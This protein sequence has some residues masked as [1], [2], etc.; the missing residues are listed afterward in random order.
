M[1]RDIVKGAAKDA[2]G[3][4]QRIAGKLIGSPKQRA[5]G[6]ARQAAGKTQKAA[7]R[8]RRAATRTKAA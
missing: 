3:R 8:A 4:I 7:G 2:L 1:N 6:T 5:K